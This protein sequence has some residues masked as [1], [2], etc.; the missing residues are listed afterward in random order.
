MSDAG[1]YRFPTL[2]EEQIVFACEGDLWTV[3][4]EGGVARRLTANPG[5]AAHPA[6]SPDG[7]SLAFTG[8]DEGHD[9]VYVM[10]AQGGEARRLTF[11]GARS[12]VRGWSPDGTRIL[13][14]SDSGQ[15]FASLSWLHA[16]DP[17]HPGATPEALDTGPA[18]SL[19]HG[20]Q[21][22][23]VIGRHT[24]DLA[25][26]K[27]YRGGLTGDLWID[28]AGDGAWRRLI[29]LEG[30]LALPMWVGA[31]IYFLSDHEGIGNLYSCL[32]S[33]EDL[34]RH[35]A[36]EDYY[37]RH[38]ATDGRRIVYHAGAD[39][40][41]FDPRKDS[42]RRV[43][44]SLRSPRPRRKRR[45]VHAADYLQDYALHPAGRAVVITG[46]G[47]PFA[48]DNHEGAVVQL[49]A[50]DGVR[51]R[52]ASWLPDGERVVMLSDAKGEETLEIH[53][54]D[55]ASPPRRFEDLD[56]GRPISLSISPTADVVALT[57]HRLE[58]IVVDLATD[59][60]EARVL[61]HSAIDRIRDVTWSPDGRWLAYAYSG[62][63][64]TAHIRLCE[65]ASG[66]VHD[67]TQPVLRDTSPAFDPEGR[68]LY[69]LSQRDFS[70]VY[71]NLHFDLGFPLGTRPYLLTLRADAP[72]PFA[73]DPIWPG[74]K[75]R[76]PKAE[77]D[78]DKEQDE[79]EGADSSDTQAEEAS[80]NGLDD[81]PEDEDR[82][83]ED[84]PEDLED[85]DLRAE[86]ETAALEIADGAKGADEEEEEEEGDDSDEDGESDAQ[87]EDDDDKPATGK[88]GK[89]RRRGRRR[90]PRPVRIDL[91]GLSE[92]VI[93]F[94][95][96][97]GR[98][99]Q[100]RAVKGKAMMLELPPPQ[101]AP[102]GDDGRRPPTGRLVAWDFAARK[103]EPLS[104]AVDDVVVAG[105]GA[106]MLLR[107]RR[108]LRVV[109]A[110]QKPPEANG[111]SRRTGWLNLGRIR[112]SVD[113]PA[114]WRQMLREAWRLQRDQFWVEDMAGLDWQ[115]VYARY[116][117]LVD[118]VATRAEFSDLMWE[119]QGELGTSHAYEYGGDHRRS[120]SWTRGHLG[121]D[122]RWDE[123]AEA[124]IVT[125]IVAG[126]AW[127]ARE[128]SPL[129][130]A[131]VDV[132]PGD[133][134]LAIDGRPLGRHDSPAE[135]LVH[136]AGEEVLLSFAPREEPSAQAEEGGSGEGGTG[137]GNGPPN[138]GGESSSEI[139][140]AEGA[141][142]KGDRDPDGRPKRSPDARRSFTV[143]TLRD[144]RPLRYRA[145]VKANRRWVHE[146][147]E[148]RVG[149]VHIPD[150][151]TR[152]YAEFHRGFLAEIDRE[153]LI[154]DVRYNGGG[155]VSPLIL[156][157]LARKR[158][159]Y[160]VQRWGSPV[161]Y[162]A[163]SVM[164]PMVALTNEAAGSDGDMFSHAFKLMGLGPL[165]G[166]RTWGG[167]IGIWPRAA[168]VDGSVTT[169]PEFSMWFQDIGWALENRGAD[170]D[171]MVEIRP[172]DHAAKQDPQLER[173]VS[174]IQALLPEGPLS[175]P[176]FA[177]PPSRAL[178]R[179]PGGQEA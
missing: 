17:E 57:N 31:R 118:R 154:V 151:G 62:S 69:F 110:G 152:G 149:Y 157:K 47:K 161:P 169:Q 108:R 44:V 134:L 121:A 94:P 50:L 75:P 175:L 18:L 79:A 142:S 146:A 21:G 55:G 96:A 91:E 49:G 63:R 37:A 51:H 178:P 25:R 167:V 166:V 29:E 46:R 111:P 163:E 129:A 159:G 147:T 86:E 109:K 143:R 4:A 115:A 16:V 61:D 117:P 168:L 124:W 145:W 2:N 120:P 150:M 43:P 160:D 5:P 137:E 53:R 100:L 36:H 24:T 156:E 64:Q 122:L 20:P 123:A 71:D 95:M 130:R 164:G 148:G 119:M 30:N 98:Y 54:I 33:G 133:R 112:I 90:K 103:Q 82:P 3:D 72:D 56:L 67:A 89:G 22:G 153:G 66:A 131:G 15:P 23:R 136:R 102:S 60:P 104:E 144:E 80:G 113:P 74:S 40:Y 38:P 162:P 76:R 78:E 1:Y 88:A 177:P 140:A 101:G 11:L 7:R 99:R 170:P 42:V 73:P 128:G 158:L 141:D 126:D 59:E 12:L 114:E 58:L 14:S 83:E 107:S 85:V 139:S 176:D 28:V 127:D 52:L 172:Q 77:R 138:A 9:E 10:D 27:R 125:D 32:P 116:L 106:W 65:V 155:H 26:W 171:I 84:D 41:L 8:R 6:L 68:Y 174:E 93:A 173:A 70:P 13:C 165:V 48:M 81:E 45:F 34:R 135:A 105:R 179:L 87:E 39:L 19:S 35:T 132:R 92:R 97:E